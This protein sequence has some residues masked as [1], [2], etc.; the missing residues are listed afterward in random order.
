MILV[1]QAEP[2]DIVTLLMQTAPV[3]VMP[4]NRTGRSDY[5][6]GG[7]DNKTRQFG[8]VQASELLADIDSMEDELRRY[9]ENA[10]ENYQIIEGIISSSPL[11][12]YTPKQYYAIRSGKIGIRELRYEPRSRIPE[13]AITIRPAFTGTPPR[14]SPSSY[15]YAYKVETITDKYGESIGQLIGATH[16]VSSSMLNAWL[17]QL[18]QAGVPT[19]HTV[20]WVDTAKLLAAIYK[21]CQ[22]PPEEHKT[23][24]RYIRPRIV[25]KEQNPFIR[26][27]M[28]ISAVY[29]IGIGEDRA[30]KIAAQYGSILDIAMS[31]VNELCQVDGIGK[32]IAEKLLTAIGR[33]KA[34]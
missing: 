16:K 29:Q 23:L 10:D 24:N 13:E 18:S 4:L 14:L 34:Q 20:N 12:T 3:N 22:K 7:E 31:S 11:A 5:Y 17:Y 9:Y 6:F 21:N 27:L 8:R 30:T 33:T 1:D 25:I 15:L 19:F 26:A 28:S 2:E 32:A